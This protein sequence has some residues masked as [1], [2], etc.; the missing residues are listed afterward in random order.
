K[1]SLPA[2]GCAVVIVRLLRV[3]DGSL[4]VLLQATARV[5]LVELSQ[6]EPFP[7]GRVEP[8]QETVQDS[9]ELEGLVMNLR[10]QFQK[11]ISQAPNMPEELSIAVANIDEPGRLADFVAA[12]SAFSLADKQVLLDE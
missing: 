4:Q 8:V 11:L 1:E 12:N 7:A 6:L 5:R 2:T 9:M 3:P 10:G